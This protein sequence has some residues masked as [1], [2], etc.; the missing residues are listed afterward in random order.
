MSITLYDQGQ[1]VRITALFEDA[2]G[3]DVDPASVTLRVLS[4]SAIL[5]TYTYGASP[6]EITR[7]SVGNYHFDVTANEQGDYFYEWS[8]TGEG[9]GV[10]E[11]QFMVRPSNV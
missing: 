9:A 8:S 1:Q 11:S 7:D 10:Q 5:S 6:D 3:N 2:D 4:P